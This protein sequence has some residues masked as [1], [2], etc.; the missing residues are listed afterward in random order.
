MAAASPPPAPAHPCSPLPAGTSGWHTH[1]GDY[2][3]ESLEPSC[4]FRVMR[5]GRHI[6]LASIAANGQLLCAAGAGDSLGLVSCNAGAWV[7]AGAA[8]E[9]QDGTI[10]NSRLPDKVG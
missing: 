1:A 7:G 6:A 2:A 5:D 9:R 10:V 8:W 4:L 3:V